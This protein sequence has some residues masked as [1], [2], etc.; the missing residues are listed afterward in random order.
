MCHFMINLGQKKLL[1]VFSCFL[2]E[3]N[4]IIP[5]TLIESS[6]L[7]LGKVNGGDGRVFL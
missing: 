2:I 3:D 6:C 7:F 1:H 5:S 4:F